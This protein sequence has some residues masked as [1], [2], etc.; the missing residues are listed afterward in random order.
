MICSRWHDRWTV[1]KS[2]RLHGGWTK[3]VAMSRLPACETVAMGRLSSASL[4]GVTLLRRRRM[5]R[6]SSIRT[7][8]IMEESL[9][10]LSVFP[11]H[12]PLICLLLSQL[13][14]QLFYFTP[15]V[16]GVGRCSCGSPNLLQAFRLARLP[17]V[18]DSHVTV[19]QHGFPVS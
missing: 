13:F 9:Y 7:T 5:W 4:N 12:P 10:M 15:Q 19:K 3:P 16:L 11:H 17:F 18:G 8:L 6:V 1:I 14:S 2:L